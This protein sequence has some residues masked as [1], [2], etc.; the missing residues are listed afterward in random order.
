MAVDEK[1]IK[2]DFYTILTNAE[3]WRI[4]MKYRSMEYQTLVLALLRFRRTSL[5]RVETVARDL[6]PTFEALCSMVFLA[7]VHMADNSLV[8]MHLAKVL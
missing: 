3:T 8:E 4:A 2:Q 7:A 5:D 1:Y 6:S